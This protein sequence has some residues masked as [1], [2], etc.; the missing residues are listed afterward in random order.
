VL[1]LTRKEGEALVIGDVIKIT[2]IGKEGDQVYLGIAAQPTPPVEE[3]G[4]EQAPAAVWRRLAGRIQRTIKTMTIHA[5]KL[6]PEEEPSALQ[7]ACHQAAKTYPGGIKAIASQNGLNARTFQNKL[8]PAE[9]GC[10]N[11]KEFEAVLRSTR[12]QQI[13]EALADLLQ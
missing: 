1:T 10:I 12:S 2:L 5:R 8:N 4:K 7:L 9:P 6:L 11:P 13:V 3:A